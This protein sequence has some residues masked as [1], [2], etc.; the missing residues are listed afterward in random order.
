L[1]GEQSGHTPSFLSF[2]IKPAPQIVALI[3][4]QRDLFT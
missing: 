2:R 4:Q 1:I 3:L